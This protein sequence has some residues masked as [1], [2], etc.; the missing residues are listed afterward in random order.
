MQRSIRD[1][2]G[3]RCDP[4]CPVGVMAHDHARS[5]AGGNP[6][7]L[8]DYGR[9]GSRGRTLRAALAG[10]FADRPAEEIEDAVQSAC[11]AFLA[12]GA[13]IADPAAVH[14]WLRTTAHRALLRELTLRRRSGPV[15]PAGTVIEAASSDRP[16]PAEELI[17][18]EDDVDLDLLVSEVAFALPPARREVLALWATGLGRAE[19]STRL[20]VSERAVKRSLEQIMGE[21]RAAIA[22]KAGGG[23]G[24]GEELVLRSACGLT[25]PADTARAHGHLSVCLRCSVFAGRL[26]AWREKAGALLPV[27]VAAEATSR[28]LLGHAV[29]RAGQAIDTVTRHLLGGGARVREGAGASYSRTVDPTP[30]AGVRPGAVAA[31]VAG[32]IAVGGGATYCANQGLD[33]IGAA[34]ELIAGNPETKEAPPAKLEPA[35]ETAAKPPPEDAP[36]EAANHEPVPEAS[37]PEPMPRREVVKESRP[38]RR[39]KTEP[40][41]APEPQPEEVT[42]PPEQSFEPASPEYPATEVSSSSPG[43]SSGAGREAARPAPVPA[44]E[45]PQFGGP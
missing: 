12:G 40:E 27:P 24:E 5:D 36:T 44:N 9:E 3:A 20:G 22:R 37:Q 1:L 42:P 13:G 34:D 11:A 45:A 17:A 23:C 41:P 2:K 15:E 26:E 33:P 19:I 21:A 28:G 8:T 7:L 38:K 18:L 43:S 25:G 30:L 39:A 35:P 4:S 6:D 29:E 32:C 10:R 31:V 14:S 16:G